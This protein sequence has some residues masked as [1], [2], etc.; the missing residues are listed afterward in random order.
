GCEVSG[1]QLKPETREALV[2][3]LAR[4]HN[5]PA[6]FI[7]EC[8]R[9]A[10]WTDTHGRSR[11]LRRWQEKTCAAIR[12]HLLTGETLVR[13]LIR[14]CHGAGKTFFAAALV[15]WWIF[16]RHNSR[17]LTLAQTWSGV[18]GL[19]WPEIEK[20]Y[21]QSVFAHLRWGK[22]TETKLDLGKTYYAI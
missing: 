12:Q 8:L 9:L 2:D 10:P 14:S 17:T 16:T 6:L 11:T 13:V 5:D 7:R 3:L 19:L 21:T 22:L 20:L 4:S 15:L 18:E 1:S